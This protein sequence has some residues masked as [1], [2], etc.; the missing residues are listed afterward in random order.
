M[1][2]TRVTAATNNV[3]SLPNKPN[4]NGYTASTLKAVFDT[5]GAALK[6]Y[7]NDTLLAELEGTSAAG[8]IG[9]TSIT[10]MTAD[11]VQEALE[12]LYTD[13]VT[14]RR[15]ACRTGP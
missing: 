3:S 9:I 11:D 2:F 7:I 6:T 8:N 12:E 4:E 15:A 1:A 5:I 14:R 13:I 10:G